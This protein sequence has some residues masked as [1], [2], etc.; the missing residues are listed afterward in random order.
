MSATPSSV[1]AHP[2]KTPSSRT[3]FRYVLTVLIASLML[4]AAVEVMLRAS[5][6]HEEIDAHIVERIYASD[7]RNVLLGDSHFRDGFR[8]D[9]PG[10]MNLAV[11]GSNTRMMEIAAREFFRHRTPGRVMVLAGAQLFSAPRVKD[12][13]H[14]YDEFFAQNA[15]DLPFRLYFFEPGIA[16][17]LSRD[18][19]F[20][21][22]SD[23]QRLR[24]D[25]G[26]EGAPASPANGSTALRGDSAALRRKADSARAAWQR[27]VPNF[28]R[29]P[30][31]AA[32]TRMIESLAER[33]AE[34]CMLRTPLSSNFAKIIGG[35]AQY[36]A[37]DSAFRAIAQRYHARY[38]D[39]RD[40]PM[41][42]AD[43]LFRDQDHLN[44]SGS[45]QFIPLAVQGCFPDSPT[46]A[47]LAR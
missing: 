30:D 32:Y 43:S 37:A 36:A 44:A 16:R 12:N 3:H 10:F 35:D 24:L 42:L 33:G 13:V 45:R 22:L 25:A 6:V 21:D 9:T 11:A 5:V 29:T 7:M 15:L 27:P 31:Y 19:H 47:P 1:P 4:V 46:G 8:F 41:V 40:L 39:S 23:L 38:V 17:H 28:E 14:K 26:F 18:R 20:F 34:I 2:V